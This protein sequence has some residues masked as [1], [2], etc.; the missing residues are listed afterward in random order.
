MNAA[1]NY[2]A[3][4][5]WLLFPLPTLNAKLKAPFPAGSGTTKQLRSNKMP[6]IYIK[7][8]CIANLEYLVYG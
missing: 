7:F 2:V 6:I 5:E 1:S 4:I 8:Y 3:S